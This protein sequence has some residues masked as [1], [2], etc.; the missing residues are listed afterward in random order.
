MPRIGMLERWSSSAHE[1]GQ[2][3]I[4]INGA[5]SHVAA[6][7]IIAVNQ[8]GMH[9]DCRASSNIPQ[10]VIAD[11]YAFVGSTMKLSS[12]VLEDLRSGLAPSDIAA[13]NHTIH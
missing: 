5:I 6:V 11:E 13:E 7:P 1:N 10:Q 4:Q 12:S 3:A 2:Y 8:Y 9:P